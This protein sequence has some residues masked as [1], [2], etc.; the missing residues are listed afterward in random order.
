MTDADIVILDEPT[1]GIDVGAKHEIYKLMTELAEAGKGII[2]ISSETPEFIGMC[3]RTVIMYK[4]RVTGEL[5]REELTMESLI[6]YSVGG[7][8]L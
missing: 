1:R 7:A 5:S 6:N 3:D 8:G 4:G 2:M